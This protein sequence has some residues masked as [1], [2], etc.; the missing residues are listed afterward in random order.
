MQRLPPHLPRV[1]RRAVLAALA[2][3]LAGRPARA[4]TEPRRVLVIGDSQAQGL[5]AG[6]QRLYRRDR[7]FRI[8]DHSKVATGLVTRSGYDW[9]AQVHTL[10]DTEHADIAVVMFGANDR[11]PVRGLN[12]KQDPALSARFQQS[13]GDRVKD[14]VQTLHQAH[15]A[16]IWVGHPIVRDPLFAE[17]M[18]FLNSVFA[19][20]AG[21]AGAD[22][23]PIW[24]LFAAPD[25]SYA[26]YGKGIEGET[27]R[28]RADDGVHLTFAGYD[29]LAAYLDPHIQ[30]CRATQATLLAS[31]P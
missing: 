15:M 7:Q 16:V 17:D 31:H 3:L 24:T 11:P 8:L 22:F 26:P 18:V 19:D 12:G 6:L 4:D 14:I 28:L 1:S 9:P 5:A 13:Y 23:V 20:A 10:A 25:G 2:V 29:V 30:A 21:A 27:T